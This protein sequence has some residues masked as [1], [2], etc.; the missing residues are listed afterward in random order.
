MKKNW[1]DS[2]VSY[3]SP[4]AG[5]R[6]QHYRNVAKQLDA[7]SKR[8]FEAASQSSKFKTWKGSS[9]QFNSVLSAQIATLRARS[10]DLFHNNPNAKRAVNVAA[11]NV[12]GLGIKPQFIGQNKEEF[13]RI[14][15]RWADSSACDF[16]ER[17]TFYGLQTMWDER[18]RLD[19]GILIQRVKKQ[20]GQRRPNQI[21]FELKT[22]PVDRLDHTYTSD[23]KTGKIRNGV[24]FDESGKEVAYHIFKNDSGQLNRER[25]RI[26]KEDII[27]QFDR[28]EPGQRI[29]L[30]WLAPVV[31][32]IKNLDTLY[33]SMLQK[34]IVSAAFAAFLEKTDNG[35]LSIA[36]Q[37]SEKK[38]DEVEIPETI[39]SG[40][41]AKLPPGY[42]ITST[43]PP[44]TNDFASFA[45]HFLCSIAA[46]LGITY[47]ALTQDWSNVNFSSARMGFLEFQ[48]M[49][50][51]W[52]SNVMKPVLD[53]VFDW[54]IEDLG[55]SSGLTDI[56]VE[57]SF[58]APE[59]IDPTKE[60]SA[61]AE[62]ISTFQTTVSEVLR[63]RGKDPDLV[64]KERA[65]ELNK[66]KQLGILP[67]PPKPEKVDNADKKPNKPEAA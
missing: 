2:L 22:I 52:Q 46:G 19:G 25:I 54:I 5:L 44:Q 60:V 3:F 55:Q 31:R 29:G 40:T 43:N 18:M 51:R 10:N 41:I 49:V 50:K 65:D 48:R 4:E 27:H 21:N 6:R 33:D 58:P 61:A 38:E 8:S 1:T 30:P 53:R 66:M 11:T 47:E 24:E 64:L 23:L 16:E 57:W 63:S 9:E 45:K 34:Q 59:M 36:E 37:L 26:P 20:K 7:V 62:A 12:V 67:E 15:S 42:K 14:F 32:T 35:Q 56:D 28:I 39:T 17:G 13:T